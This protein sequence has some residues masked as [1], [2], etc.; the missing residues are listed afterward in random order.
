MCLQ[1]LIR[2]FPVYAGQ[3]QHYSGGDSPYSREATWLSGYNTNSVLYKHIA[4]LNAIRRQAISTSAKYT[5][6]S[7]KVIYSDDHNIVLKKGLT[8]S[9]VVTVTTNFGHEADSYTLNLNGTDYEAG[10]EVTNVLACTSATVDEDGNLDA[11]I[12]GGL[13]LVSATNTI[14]LHL[15]TQLIFLQVFYPTEFLSGSGICD[16]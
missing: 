9:Q 8:G 11:T 2:K 4:T 1:A 16:N 5:T 3:E 15:H 7:S 14:F 12:T 10:Q 13:P 6:T